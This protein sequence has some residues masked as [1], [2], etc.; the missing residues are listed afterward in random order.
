G[1]TSA[2][3]DAGSLKTYDAVVIITDHTAVNYEMVLREAA[4]VVDTRGV[5]RRLG[6]EGDNVVTA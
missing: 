2:P 4:L 1:L 3:L 6:Y 5:A